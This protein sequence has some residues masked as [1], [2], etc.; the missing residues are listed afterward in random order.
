VTHGQEQDDSP[1]GR[2]G[3]S[4]APW[5]FLCLGAV[6][7]G[8]LWIAA[9]ASPARAQQDE[10]GDPEDTGQEAP[11]ETPGEDE[12]FGEPSDAPPADTTGIPGFMWG[13]APHYSTDYRLTRQRKDW[14]QT[15]SFGRKVGPWDLRG[16]ADFTIGRDSGQGSDDRDGN[17]R[18]T[19]LYRGVR[20]VPVTLD[21]RYAKYRGTR[22]GVSSEDVQ[23]D[24][25][26]GAKY[27]G[28]WGGIRNTVDVKAGLGDQSKESFSSFSSSNTSDFGVTG[29]VDWKGLWNPMESLE[30]NAGAHDERARKQS[31]VNSDGSM[32]NQDTGR[33]QTKFNIDVKYNPLS[34]MSGDLVASDQTG[35]ETLPITLNG[36]GSIETRV[37]ENRAVGVNFTLNPRRNLELKWDMGTDSNLSDLSVQAQRSSRGDGQNWKG[38]LTTILLGIDVDS[39]LSWLSTF[40]APRTSLS[41]ERI[42]KGV[43]T[44]FHRR[45]SEKFDARWSVDSR[46]R[47]SFYYGTP[48][49]I[50]DSDELRTKIDTGLNYTPG[51][52]WTAT[53]AYVHENTDKLQIN[54]VAASQTNTE[55]NQTINIGFTYNWSPKTLISQVYYIQATLTR[56]LYSPGNNRENQTQRINTTIETHALRRVLLRLS[57]NFNLT[58]SGTFTEGGAGHIFNRANRTYRQDLTTRIEY[59]PLPWVLLHAQEQF[60]RSDVVNSSTLAKTVSRNL[61]LEYGLNLQRTLNGGVQVR[62]DGA[63]VRN[64]TSPSFL[65][66][67]SSLDKTF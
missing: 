15:L 50:Q 30:V 49:E 61:E 38:K 34:W 3:P 47:Q 53:L 42:N 36:Q 2:I 14:L 27:T 28:F 21:F 9:D 16:T 51:G 54:R 44:K 18:G 26:L 37:S 62:V 17:A 6:L 10:G 19:F 7:A 35:H 59:T 43:Q 39:E 48:D 1:R 33:R 31:T 23:T 52:K 45:L 4:P 57:H 56:F 55:E 13:V 8:L 64:S 66:L 63:Y 65:R 60:L 25:S 12:P 46:L 22:P 41:N 20:K 58:D 32:L 5:V 11:G 24:G 29:T 40:I 67:Q